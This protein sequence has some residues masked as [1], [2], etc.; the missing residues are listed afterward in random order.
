MSQVQ[1]QHWGVLHL[2]SQDSSLIFINVLPALSLVDF[3]NQ[4]IVASEKQ[5][6]RIPKSWPRF[7]WWFQPVWDESQLMFVLMWFKAK[8]QRIPNG[9]PYFFQHAI[10]FQDGIF[11]S[12][13]PMVPKGSKW[14][15]LKIGY[16]LNRSDW[17]WL[18]II[19]ILR[20]IQTSLLF[21]KH[22][23]F[24]FISHNS[25]HGP[26][27]SNTFQYIP[28]YSNIFQYIPIYLSIL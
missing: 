1:K 12:R 5:P 9:S 11:Y 8:W 25:Q 2:N 19:S 21:L 22:H 18:I 17:Y 7:L 3:S 16:P 4:V 27:H 10:T 6:G 20:H 23:M 13:R 15:C 24:V 28:I 14:A 26:I